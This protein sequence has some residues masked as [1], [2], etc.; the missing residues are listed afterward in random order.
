[1]FIQDIDTRINNEVI[2]LTIF[3]EFNLS[4]QI[5][6]HLKKVITRIFNKDMATIRV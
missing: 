1:M 3:L 6:I 5:F 2:D 4:H